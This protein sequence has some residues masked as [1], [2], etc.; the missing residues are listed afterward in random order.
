M[1]ECRQIQLSTL[2]RQR[3]QHLAL[4]LR[5]KLAA[6]TYADMGGFQN[7]VGLAGLFLLFPRGELGSGWRRWLLLAIGVAAVVGVVTTLF[8][9]GV[10][11][12]AGFANPWHIES[13]AWIG[14]VG[15]ALVFSL[16]ILLA[17]AVADFVV[18]TI[19]AR[20][21]ER[22]QYK[23]LA[24]AAVAALIGMVLTFSGHYAGIDL[25]VVWTVAIALIPIAAMI[26]ITRHHLY[27][28]DRIVSRTVSYALVVG[29]LAVVYAGLVSLAT[30]VLPTDSALAVAGAT[31]AVAPLFN[32]LRIRVQNRVDHRFNRSRYNSQIVFDEFA[33]S[34]REH[35]DLDGVTSGLIDVVIQT[36]QP[37]AAGVWVKHEQHVEIS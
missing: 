19:R 16:T 13:A 9:S 5:P 21:T 8:D 2:P 23:W 4:R 27:D 35:T 22:Q 31:L 3:S 18:R 29:L 30:V 24:A 7:T 17:T 6:H 32:P 20:G 14:T 33:A 25:S 12:L 10:Y 28:I 37:T 11:S 34:L 1:L 36:M 15:D 26:A